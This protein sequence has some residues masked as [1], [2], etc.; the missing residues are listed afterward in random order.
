VIFK[1]FCRFFGRIE[2]TRFFR[3]KKLRRSAV[4]SWLSKWIKFSAH[5]LKY[6][7]ILEPFFWISEGIGLTGVSSYFWPQK[8]IPL[9]SY[10]T[11]FWVLFT[12]TWKIYHFYWFWVWFDVKFYAEL[13]KVYFMGSE[14]Q[15]GAQTV[16]LKWVV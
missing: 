1:F 6:P 7:F 4:F 5:F 14:I 16:K 12:S 2:K 10:H 8:Q 13:K 3:R 11:N 15:S 9:G